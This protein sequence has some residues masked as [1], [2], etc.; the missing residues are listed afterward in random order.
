M[1]LGGVDPTNDG[2]GSRLTK[3][4]ALVLGLVALFATVDLAG[5][6]RHGT[7]MAHA[8]VEGAIAGA[9][10]RKAGLSGRRDLAAFFRGDLLGP[11][12]A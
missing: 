3:W 4:L 7:T 5:D 2:G 6:L 9:I 12:P 1:D 8:L 11:R 10:Y